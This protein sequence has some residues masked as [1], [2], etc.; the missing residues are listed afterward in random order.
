M[1]KKLII[2]VSLLPLCCNAMKQCSITQYGQSDSKEH[3]YLLGCNI[4]KTD[5]SIGIFIYEDKKFVL[6]LELTQKTATIENFTSFIEDVLFVLENHYTITIKR[7]CFGVPGNPSAQHNFIQPFNISFAVDANSLYENTKLEQIVIINDFEVIGYGIDVIDPQKVIQIN[8]GKERKQWPKAIVGAGDGLGSCLMIWD[9]M[10]SNYVPSPLGF[11]YSDFTP[12]NE[13][14]LDLMNFIKKTSEMQN[15]SWG[16]LL[17]LKGGIKKIYEFLDQKQSYS[18]NFVVYNSPQ[19]IFDQAISN[20]IRCKDAVD[21]Y[22]KLYI[23]LLRNVAYTVLPY[24]GLYITNKV[25][26][27]NQNLF[28]SELFFQEML[29]CNNDLLAEIVKEIPVY[30]VVE[31]KVKLYGAVQYLLM[32]E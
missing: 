32:N 16:Y 7:A 22:M 21:Y 13:L 9:T 28:K 3:E 11:C 15:I 10:Q 29:E 30:I 6:L 23:R 20:D 24:G 26:E 27:Q 1:L 31:P 18:E 5:T 8:P 2:L 25:V 12:H 14:D 19:E 17:G 4:S